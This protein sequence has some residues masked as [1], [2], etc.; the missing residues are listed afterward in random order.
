MFLK[1][2]FFCVG[3][4]RIQREDAGGHGCAGEGQGGTRREPGGARRATSPSDRQKEV[5]AQAEQQEQ[6]Q[7]KQEQQEQEEPGAE[8]RRPV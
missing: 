3:F 6:E 5:R 4:I 1:K 2:Y 7:E 8:Q